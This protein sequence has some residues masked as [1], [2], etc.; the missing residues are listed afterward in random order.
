MIKFILIS[1]I[2]LAQTGCL[3][4]H[5]KEASKMSEPTVSIGDLIKSKKDKKQAAILTR[6]VEA[7]Q[8]GHESIIVT[9]SNDC[10]EIVVS[11]RYNSDDDETVWQ[12]AEQYFLDKKTGEWKIGWQETPMK[13]EPFMIEQKD[14]PP[15]PDG[16]T[17]LVVDGD[18]G[19]ACGPILV[20]GKQ[21]SF[22]IHVAG[23][24]A[25]GRHI[26]EC[27]KKVKFKIKEGTTFHFDDWNF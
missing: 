9:E 23:S 14:P 15:S 18:N 22:P 20:D 26:I 24:I 13:T 4:P 19:G 16:K 21:W 3:V 6:F 8:K 5:Q 7:F 2:L 1:L 17:Y 27:G 10:Y 11:H 25:P 12:S